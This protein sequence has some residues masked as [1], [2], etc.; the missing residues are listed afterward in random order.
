VTA[1]VG[2]DASRKRFAY[3]GYLLTPRVVNV[4]NSA[5]PPNEE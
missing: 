5:A 4:A 1:A 3:Y 2:I